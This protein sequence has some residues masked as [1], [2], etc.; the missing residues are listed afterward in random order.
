MTKTFWLSIFA[1][2]FWMLLILSTY[3]LIA[4]IYA[5]DIKAGL[6]LIWR[7]FPAPVVDATALKLAFPGQINPYPVN[8]SRT[9]GPS[10]SL[11]ATLG[12]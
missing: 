7:S 12:M 5:S 4:L 2:P 6:S 8:S 11:A 3:T 1:S 10:F 9:L